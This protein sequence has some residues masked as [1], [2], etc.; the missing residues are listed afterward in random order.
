LLIIS[1]FAIPAFRTILSFLDYKYLLLIHVLRI[2]VEF[3]LWKLS[4]ENVIPISMTFK[5]TNFD[6]FSG[7]SAIAIYYWVYVRKQ[8]SKTLLLA[9]NIAGI[10]LLLNAFTAGILSIPSTIQKINFEHP[11]L[12]VL[13]FPFVWLPSFILPA[14]L[15]AHLAYIRNLMLE[16]SSSLLSTFNK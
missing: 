13:Y 16:R 8:E 5:G 10:I 14:I 12:A 3:V 6:L 1:V 7:I 11:N 9:W 15:F 2:P 4:Q